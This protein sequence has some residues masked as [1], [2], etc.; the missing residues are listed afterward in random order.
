MRL[1]HEE[2]IRN[3]LQNP[4]LSK[5]AIRLYLMLALQ[6]TKEIRYLT[7]EL[8]TA[9]G[10]SARQLV[11]AANSLVRCGY[12]RRTGKGRLTAKINMSKS[13]VNFTQE[14]DL[15]CV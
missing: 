11:S 1:S 8:V 6:P 3:V 10:C 12:A 15:E 4:Q 14:R 7:P 2:A 13:E 9:V 5:A